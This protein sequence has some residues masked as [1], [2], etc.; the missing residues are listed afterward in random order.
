MYVV[1]DNERTSTLALDIG[2]T[3]RHAN[4]SRTALFDSTVG[5]APVQH[6]ETR[7][8]FPSRE[9]RYRVRATVRNATASNETATAATGRATFRV[10]DGRLREIRVHIVVHER[11]APEGV[12]I[13]ATARRPTPAC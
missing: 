11:D 7:A 6:L 1:I 12:T 3:H 5:L 10:P 13:D 8:T 2:A 9:G 4:G